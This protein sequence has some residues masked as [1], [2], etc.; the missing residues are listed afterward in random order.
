[1]TRETAAPAGSRALGLGRSHVV[2][3]YVR[4]LSR[5][6]PDVGTT[7]ALS[8]CRRGGPPTGTATHRRTSFWASR[9]RGSAVEGTS[10][11]KRQRTVSHRRLAWKQRRRIAEDSPKASLNKIAI[12]RTHREGRLRPTASVDPVIAAQARGFRW[13]G[14]FFRTPTG[15]D[16][17]QHRG[18]SWPGTRI[19]TVGVR[20]T[21]RCSVLCTPESMPHT[22]AAAGPNAGGGLILC[23]MAAGRD[24]RGFQPALRCGT[25]VA[26]R[27]RFSPVRR[28]PKPL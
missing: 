16:L 3:Q 24:L 21:P 17:G 12:L 22:A 13:P 6:C 27:L 7:G 20:P 8:P 11:V 18:M 19:N 23:E 10:P 28:F 4:R 26:R 9:F 15:R 14:G 2:S 1:M 5:R 25:L